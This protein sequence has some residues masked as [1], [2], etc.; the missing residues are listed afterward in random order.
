[1]SF[2]VLIPQDIPESAKALLR[3][4]G[5]EVKM[6]RGQTESDII[7][8]IAD[9]DAVVTRTVPYTRAIFE[10]A[11]KLRIASR[12]GVGVDNIDI[13]AA[14]ELGIWVAN[15]P[16]ANSATVAE[17][18]IALILSL[19]T[20]LVDSCAET[21]KGN[22]AYR[23]QV[24]GRDL[25]GKTLA[26]IGIGKIGSHL[27]R[28]ASAG[29]GMNVI[30]YDPFISSNQV[31]D[32]ITLTPNR[33]QAFRD[34]DF[35][36]LHLPLNDETRGCIGA[37]EFSLMK[38]SSCLINCSRGEVVNEQALIAALQSG[39]IAGA[40]LDVF[41]KEP[42]EADNPLLSMKNVIVTPHDAS[43]T[44]EAF[45]RMGEHMAQNINDVISGRNPT[46]PVNNPVRK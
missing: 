45:D 26:I 37:N 4:M 12:F 28:I 18:T 1:M 32:Y 11:K 39:E 24:M 7:A 40:A 19:A 23:N 21:R 35:V 43:F 9:C 20:D 46:W 15:T 25:G 36:S 22:F 33:E 16:Q 5:C 3:K 41:E 44:H 42:P 31:P 27:A 6:G 17:H 14:T 10:A 2:S 34:A 38:K 30:A 29:F 13:N 8:D